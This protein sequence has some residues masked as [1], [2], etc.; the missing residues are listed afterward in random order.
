MGSEMCIRDRTGVELVG[1]TRQFTLG[2]IE[3]TGDPY[4]LVLA[5]PDTFLPVQLPDGTIAYRRSGRLG[6]DGEGRLVFEDG[7]MP[8]PPLVV[9]AGTQLDQI[10]PDGTVLVRAP[11]SGDTQPVG[12]LEFVR[13]PNPQGLLAAGQGRWLATDAAGQPE[14]AGAGEANSPLVMNGVREHSN[15]CLL[16]TSDAADE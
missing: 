8:L 1:T 13:F 9:P 16:Y 4:D 15:V 3:V 12:R 5:R 10:A 7:S 11:G 2:P 14:P 6:L